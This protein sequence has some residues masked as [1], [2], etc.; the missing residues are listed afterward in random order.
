MN[1]RW[2]SHRH[3]GPRRHFFLIRVAAFFAVVLALSAYGFLTLLRQAFGENTLQTAS[4]LWPVVVLFVFLVLF[5]ATMRRVGRPLG[6]V[7]AAASMCR[8]ATSACEL[9]SMVRHGS[10]PWLVRSTA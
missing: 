2:P 7:V 9:P 6:D 5:A 8:A 4:L 10:A 1:Q 3:R